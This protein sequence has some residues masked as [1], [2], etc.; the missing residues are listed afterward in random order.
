[1][2]IEVEV[3]TGFLGYGKTSF[4][5]SLLKESQVK[6]EKVLI[7]Q[8]EDGNKKISEL[9]NVNYPLKIYK[10]NDMEDFKKYCENKFVNFK[11]NRIIIEF[12]GTDKIENFIESLG[13][14][15]LRKIMK[16]STVYFVADSTKL[17]NNIDSLGYYI[18]PF[19]KYSDMIIINNTEQI[20]NDE[21]KKEINT[22]RKVNPK[23]FILNVDNK[24][25][26]SS[27]L[28]QSKVINNG[29]LKKFKVKLMNLS[30]G[31]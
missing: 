27:R 7:I 21:L 8:M 15:E 14:R 29:C 18:I 30:S 5:N 2:R 12:N 4:I 20:Q 1:M 22:L 25:N 24:R 13:D 26:L 9:N 10:S 3:V 17:S 28:Q 31:T 19:I 16:L 11:P 23:A 6:G